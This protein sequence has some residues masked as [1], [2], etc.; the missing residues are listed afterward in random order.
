MTQSPQK[1]EILIEELIKYFKSEIDKNKRNPFEQLEPEMTVNGSKFWHEPVRR[2]NTPVPLV[3]INL[4]RGKLQ[5]DITFSS[6]L[7]VENSNLVHHLFSL[8][9]QAFHFYHFVRIWIHIDEFCFKRY[10]VAIL[11]V[12]YMQNIKLMPS[13]IQMQDDVK[14]KFIEGSS[15]LQ[16]ELNCLRFKV[17]SFRLERQL[18]WNKDD[19]RLWNGNDEKLRRSSHWILQVLREL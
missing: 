12:F 13:V 4:K 10:M 17:V 8:Q 5:C 11:V 14:E 19:P 7:G 9:P 15:R 3:R 16:F 2:L 18:Q 1:V 6:G